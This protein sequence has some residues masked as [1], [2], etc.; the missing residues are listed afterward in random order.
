MVRKKGKRA[1]AMSALFFI[2]MDYKVDYT[3]F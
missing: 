3:A 2:V 1:L